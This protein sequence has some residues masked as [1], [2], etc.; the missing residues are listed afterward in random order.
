MPLSTVQDR[1]TP[2]R[3]P[4]ATGSRCSL[5]NQVPGG[6]ELS[7]LADSSRRSA[8]AALSLAVAR[9]AVAGAAARHRHRDD[10]GGHG[11]RG[12]GSRP[13][14]VP[15]TCAAAVIVY[16]APASDIVRT[17]AT[18]ATRSWWWGDRPTSRADRELPGGAR[19]GPAGQAPGAGG[20]EGGGRR[21]RARDPGRLRRRARAACRG[22]QPD[23]APAG[24]ARV[25]AQE[26]HR[27]RVARA[28]D[29]DLLVGRVRRAA[30]GRGPGSRDPRAFP[31]AGSRSGG[32]AAQAVGGFARPVAP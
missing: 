16:S 22:V 12:R 20:R 28:A 31:R 10:R 25:G 17:V 21:L 32:A 9:R 29:A 30:R 26:V 2:R 5:V 11:G 1:S 14:P 27:H 13:L 23:A 18:A 3:S 7:T 19:A 6:A 24:P 4:P 8:T 15:P